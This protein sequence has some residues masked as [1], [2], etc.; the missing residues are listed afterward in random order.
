MKR[1]AVFTGGRSDYGH[2]YWVIDGIHKSKKLELITLFPG[3]HPYKNELFKMGVSQMLPQIND[4]SD[5]GGVFEFI[6]MLM[7]KEVLGIDMLLVLGD[8]W[9]THA[10][11]TAALL[12]GTKICHIH[13]GETTEGC[14]DDELRNSITMMSQ[15]HFVSHRAYEFNVAR[16]IEECGVK[17]GECGWIHCDNIFNVGAPG[18]DW[19]T[20]A[21]LYTKAELKDKVSIDL[22]EPY[23]LACFNPVT[24]EL[25][26]TEKYMENMCKALSKN[27]QQVLLI[28]PNID[29]GNKE[30]KTVIREWTL[31]PERWQ[32]R[33]DLFNK[34]D[35]FKFVENVDHLTYLSLMKY[36]TLMVG[37]SSSGIIEAAS[38]NL[39][40]VD[41][42]NRQK[43]RIM[44]D[45]VIHCGY[46]TDEILS[47]MDKA[48]NY[49]GKV[50]NPYGDGHSS[51]KIVKVLEEI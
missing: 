2:L 9:E 21:K 24:H 16:M 42:G 35:L 11:A 36:A 12:S 38:L 20:K 18:L 3:N 26:H 23:I 51:E 6:R 14:F 46:S 15:I 5:Y 37:N 48:K 43:G 32:G 13:G 29:P 10:A 22:E 17:I 39:P 7:P 1:I 28:L 19:L 27:N 8:R 31:N 44:P 34:L 40:V 4:I 50:V 33:F 30:I 25:E 47:A 45:N 41:I 49:S